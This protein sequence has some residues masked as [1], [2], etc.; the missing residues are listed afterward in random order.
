MSPDGTFRSPL[1]K[2]LLRTARM[3]RLGMEAEGNQALLRVVD[4]LEE[5][6]ARVEPDLGVHLRA[7][8]AEIVAAQERGDLL[9]LADLAE[10]ELLPLVSE[11]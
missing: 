1:G 6:F 9:R 2:D 7:V 10:F 8:V 5:L 4:G 11:A 3:F